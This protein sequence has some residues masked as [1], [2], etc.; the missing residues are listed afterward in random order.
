MGEADVLV[1]DDANKIASAVRGYVQAGPPPE[2][3]SQQVKL[4]RDRI[5]ALDTSRQIDPMS[6][7]YEWNSN[8]TSGGV[9]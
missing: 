9:R 4:Y 1:E 2:H 5:A 8:N 6:L 3:R 7:R